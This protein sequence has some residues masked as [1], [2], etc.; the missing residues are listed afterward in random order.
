MVG[1]TRF[2]LAQANPEPIE[3]VTIALSS[4]FGM[5]L[6]K[7]SRV[8]L[9]SE[10]FFLMLFSLSFIEVSPDFIDIRLYTEVLEMSAD[11]ANIGL[12]FD[13]GKRSIPNKCLCSIW[14]G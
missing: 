14:P 8:Y 4:I 2:V 11:K 7:I 9:L 10:D 5:N 13:V 3:L 12:T 6:T 1:R